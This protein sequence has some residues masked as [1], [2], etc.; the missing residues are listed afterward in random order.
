MASTDKDSPTNHFRREV[1]IRKAKLR[2]ADRIREVLRQAF[3]GLEGR[4]YSTQAIETAIVDTNELRKRMHLGGHV[5]VAELDNEII[6]TVTGLEEHKSMHVCSLAVDPK[7]QN[8]GVAHKL[9]KYLERIAHDKGCY[10]LFLC[11]AWAMKEAIRLYESLG[12]VKEGYLHKHF[13]GEDFI[14]FGKLIKENVMDY[15]QEVRE[16]HSEELESL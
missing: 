9:M 3:K 8:Y 6:G 7:Y 16:S 15:V 5:L 10:K 12:Y 14:I 13:Y 2:E 11:T 4:G 1:V